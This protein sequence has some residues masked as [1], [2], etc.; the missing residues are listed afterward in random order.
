MDTSPARV[1]AMIKDRVTAE[2]NKIEFGRMPEGNS[3]IVAFDMRLPN[4]QIFTV[5]IEE[6]Y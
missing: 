1:A 4:G 2:Y 3:R 5:R 6:Q